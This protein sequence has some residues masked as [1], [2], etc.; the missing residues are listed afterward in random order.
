MGSRHARDRDGVRDP[1]LAELCVRDDTT[2]LAFVLPQAFT[3]AT[4]RGAAGSDEQGGYAD[5]YGGF[6]SPPPV[7]SE[8]VLGTPEADPTAGR[9]LALPMT[10]PELS[11]S[12]RVDKNHSTSVSGGLTVTRTP[13]TVARTSSR[14]EFEQI[15]LRATS[16][17][18]LT[19]ATEEILTDSRPAFVAIL[20]AAYADEFG[21]A[22]LREKIRGVG[23]SEY[24]GVLNS[25]AKIVVAKEAGQAADTVLAE[26]IMAM[27]LRAWRYDRCIWICNP[28]TR[29]Q[30]ARAVLVVEGSTGG[31]IVKLF[32]PAQAEGSPDRLDGRACYFS[33]F[34]STLGDEGDIILCDWSQFLEGTHQPLGGVESMHVRFVEH[35]RAFKFWT[36]NAGA[37]WWRAPLTPANG[38]ATLS[39]IVTLAARA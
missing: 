34:A 30:L 21:A 37:P 3:P 11:V 10:V 31:G 2:A 39:P 16:L 9:T 22:M 25:P 6:L 32:Q 24:L 15:V 38:T 12:A 36:R 14:M 19:F 23:G 27:T 26:N 13:E 8:F 35:E 18:G 5:P 29:S 33:E 7:L 17:H 4:I 28:N 1:R 20:S